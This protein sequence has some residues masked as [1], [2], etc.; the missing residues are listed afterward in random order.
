MKHC[1]KLLLLLLSEMIDIVFVVSCTVPEIIGPIAC[2]HGRL[3]QWVA[4]CHSYVSFEYW[5]WRY[6]KCENIEG[7][8]NYTTQYQKSG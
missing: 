7:G 4:R 5:V 3:F 1:Q 8:T 6:N 2:L